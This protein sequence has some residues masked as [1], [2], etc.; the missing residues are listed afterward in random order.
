MSIMSVFLSHFHGEFD[1]CNVYISEVTGTGNSGKLIN[2]ARSDN[3]DTLHEV[4]QSAYDYHRAM[5]AARG[6]TATPVDSM[7]VC[8]EETGRIFRI[9]NSNKKR[10]LD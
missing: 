2:K 3:K 7:I 1:Y 9:Q 10:I 4:L 5:L 8:V 6:T